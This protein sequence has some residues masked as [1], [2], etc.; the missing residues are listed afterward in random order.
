LTGSGSVRGAEKNESKEAEVG[1][2]EDLM[3]EHGVLK[4]VLLIYGE[5]LRRIDSKQ[6]FPPEALADAARIIRSFVEDYHEKLEEDF[7]FPR[8]EKVNLLVDLVKVPRAQHQGGRRVTDVTMR[9]ANLQSLKN[10]SERFVGAGRR[11]FD[12]RVMC[13][14]TR[15]PWPAV[16]Q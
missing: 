2:P 13:R 15:S 1:P 3:R 4:C 5:V 6:D 12:A 16:P 11:S 10:E 9:L 7:L 8:F 14:R